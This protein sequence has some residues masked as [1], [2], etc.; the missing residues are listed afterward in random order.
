MS[1]FAPY[2]IAAMSRSRATPDGDTATGTI[3]AAGCRRGASASPPSLHGTSSEPTRT[4]AP[5]RAAARSR[6]GRG[7]CRPR[8]R[9]SGSRRRPAPATRPS[10][11]STGPRAA[12]TRRSP[13][14]AARRA[15]SAHASSIAA[16]VRSS[17]G[18]AACATSTRRARA[19]ERA[20]ELRVG[21]AQSRPCRPGTR[22]AR[23]RAASVCHCGARMEIAVLPEALAVCRLR[24]VRPR[25]VV[26]ARAA[27]LA[28]L[29]HAHARRALDRVPRG[30]RARGRRAPSPAG[31]RSCCRGRSGS[32]SRACSRRS[33]CRSPPPACRSSPCRPT[34][35][36]TCW[37]AKAI[38]SARWPRC[39]PS[40][41]AGGSPRAR[42]TS[43]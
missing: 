42:R 18:R 41:I 43:R 40:A 32:S 33:P 8:A 20:G 2:V 36:T 22:S 16:N 9:R 17:G 5:R 14:R 25:A 30:G 37:S 21:L 35:P 27:R 13:A 34:T 24:P 29:G 19:P 31:G 3:T 10:S 6:A 11:S 39:G 12:G 28:R 26:G 1:G 7:G 23:R 15:F 4:G 38:S